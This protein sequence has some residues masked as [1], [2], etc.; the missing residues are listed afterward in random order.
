[1]ERVGTRQANN[2]VVLQRSGGYRYPASVMDT[3]G[4]LARLRGPGRPRARRVEP[5]PTTF[6]GRLNR[7]FLS[8]FPP[9]GD[10][11]T[12]ADLLRVL[13][14]RGVE[15]SA[16]YLSQ[17]RTGERTGPSDRIIA[18]IARFF[19][20][21]PDYLT[22]ENPGYIRFLDEELRWL[23]LAHDAGVRTVTT[24]LLALRPEEREELLREVVSDSDSANFDVTVGDW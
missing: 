2:T 16:P 7:L 10:P 5:A 1:M 3:L 24:A 8:V 22:G 15:L 21:H 19:G 20:I 6:A 23:D 9:G 12:S 4:S 14:A 13:D 18:E 17:L 11:Y